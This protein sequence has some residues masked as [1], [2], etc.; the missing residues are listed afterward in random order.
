MSK[1]LCVIV[2]ALASFVLAESLICNQCSVGL[3]GYCLNQSN[4]TCS[5]NTSVCFTARTSFPD[6]SN[7]A[8]INTQGCKEPAGCNTTTTSLINLLSI[9]YTSVISCCSTDNCNPVTIT[10]GSGT[11]RLSLVAVVTGTM[12]ASVWST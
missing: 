6:I 2:A 8:G 10:S 9:N 4:I 1:I 3:F 12:L 5:T 11:T 7:F